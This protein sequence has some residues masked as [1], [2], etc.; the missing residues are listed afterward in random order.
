MMGR[1]TG[2]SVTGWVAEQVDQIS[3]QLD[4]AMLG[5][6]DHTRGLN[7]QRPL[8]WLTRSSGSQGLSLHSRTEAPGHISS[9]GG[10][11]G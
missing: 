7:P 4:Q 2:E 8:P 5:Q 10:P 3:Q 1:W 6:A 11:L 9:L